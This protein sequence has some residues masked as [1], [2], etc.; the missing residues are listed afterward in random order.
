MTIK[1]TLITAATLAT[2]ISGGASA[3]TLSVGS[4]PVGYY[5]NTV[6]NVPEATLTSFGD[7]FYFGGAYGDPGSFCA[8]SGG[9]CQA[10]LQIAFSSVVS[11]LLFDVGG[12]QTGDHVLLSIF[13][14]ADS[15]LGT[16]SI[17]SN[18]TG[19]DLSSFGS[20]TRL[21]FDDSST[22][23]GVGYANFS[24]DQGGVEVPEPAGVALFGLGVALLGLSRRSKAKA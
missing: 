5:G 12:W 23:A 7:D 13:G 22:A 3:A 16:V 18:I 24:F 20:I 9:S 11:N 21:Y 10:D 19:L 6:A 1:K 8:I 17:D 15:L 14:V 2:L 4:L